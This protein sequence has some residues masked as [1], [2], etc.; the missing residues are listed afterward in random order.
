MLGQETFL[1]QGCVFGQVASCLFPSAS[2]LLQEREEFVFYLYLP[3]LPG[4]TEFL[5]LNADTAL[6]SSI[7]SGSVNAH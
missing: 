3:G 1:S 6:K 4:Q 2:E 5:S 7:S